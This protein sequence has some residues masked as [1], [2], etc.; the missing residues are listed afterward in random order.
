[1]QGFG[2]E[3]WLSLLIFTTLMSFTPGPNTMLSSALAAN[4]GLKRALPFIASVPVGW[5]ALLWL[6]AAG[7]GAVVKTY[8]PIGISIKVLGVA[9]LCWLAWK[10]L[11]SHTVA[12]RSDA[13]PVTFLQGA[14]LQFVN[15]KAWFGS[16]TIT[17]AWIATAPDVLTRTL[18]LTPVFMAFAFASNFTY[19]FVGASLRSWL[20]VGKRLAYFN[21]ALAVALVL[22]AIWMLRV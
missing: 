8:P 20:L 15:I 22:T 3:Q 1:M 6:C 2:M 21:T 13:V 11:H 17:S 10:I 18:W 14:L 9:Y 5:V 4:Y 16:L 12:E 19:A 7:I